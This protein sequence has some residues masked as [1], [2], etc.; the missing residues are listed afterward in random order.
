[1]VIFL[2]V[3]LSF[4]SY[5]D[6]IVWDWIDI[7]IDCMF[8]VDLVLT[9]FTAYLENEHLVVSMSRIAIN[10]F[11]LW[12]WV[13]LLSII[14]FEYIINSTGKIIALG[15]VARLSRL[16]NLIKLT[17]LAKIMRL[18]RTK[19]GFIYH[20][21][22][23]LNISPGRLT[24]PRGF[25]RIF[26]GFVGVILF[27]HLFACLWHFSTLLG[28]DQRSWVVR[29]HLQDS[30]I[31]E[32]YICSLYW[33]MQTVTT[34]GY[35]DVGAG[36]TLERILCILAMFAGVI[37]FSLTVGSLT[38]ILND[39]DIKNSIY[40]TKCKKLDSIV[41]YFGVTD[42]A[43]ICKI[44]NTIKY[45]VFTNE[46]SVAELMQGLPRNLAVPL[47]GIIYKP[48]VKGIR[49]FED[50]DPELLHAI[51]PFLISIKVANNEPIINQ[52][53]Y[54]N[55]VYFIQRGSVGLTLKD[56]NN[57]VF[58]TI[59]E[60][61]YFGETEILFCCERKFSM[62][63]MGNLDLLAL[64]RSHFVRIFFKEFK[65]MGRMIKSYAERR[66]AKQL[67]TCDLFSSILTQH[68][69]RRSKTLSRNSKVAKQRLEKEYLPMIAK[70]TMQEADL[71]FSNSF[72]ERNKSLV[73]KLYEKEREG[74][75]ILLDNVSN[76][77]L[78]HRMIGFPRR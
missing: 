14:P 43:L 44:A 66:L 9:F 22:E 68:Y 39:L 13:D 4:Y 48:L 3:Q 35:G 29:L 63:A 20:I 54:A 67:R 25:G 45:R 53:E 42:Q 52:G 74:D 75:D 7:F 10:Y 15:K 1:M 47:S 28:N 8:F 38:S 58:M 18:C 71:K 34:V 64:E 60:G 24:L 59:G 76:Q 2:P 19:S 41:S 55:E 78:L 12:F 72:L 73:P 5:S 51:G 21:H 23:I 16:Y 36:N 56:F 32:R 77:G 26:L 31:T 27:C 70:D 61:Q 49:I 37:F 57:E 33:I 62:V 46:E 50:A 40:E 6:N 69:D 65:E 17:R 11:K 30:S